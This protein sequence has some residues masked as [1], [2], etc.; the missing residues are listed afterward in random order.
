MIAVGRGVSVY[1]QAG[2]QCVDQTMPV[3]ANG[4]V[5]QAGVKADLAPP[6]QQRRCEYRHTGGVGSAIGH[7]DQHW[8]HQFAELC[9]QRGFLQQ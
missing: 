4:F 5:S 2:V 9:M 8:H 6:F 7:A 3:V 1:V